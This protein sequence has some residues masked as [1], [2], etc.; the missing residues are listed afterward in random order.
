MQPTTTTPRHARVSLSHLPTPLEP[1]DRLAAHLGRPAGTLWVKR[2]DLTGLAGGGNKVRKLEYVLADALAHGADHVVTLGGPQSNA[3]RMTAAAAARLGLGC[4]LVLDG[5]RPATVSGNLLLDLLCGADIRWHPCDSVEEQEAAIL[6][7]CADLAAAGARPYA[8]TVG[9]SNALGSLGYVDVARE[10]VH[11]LPDVDTVVVA[12][13]SCGTQAGLVAGFGDHA[14]VLGVRVGERR[15][16]A[17]RVARL[18]EETAA[19]AG[20]PTPVGDV[21]LDEDHLGAGYGEHTDATIAAMVV[22]ARLEA[23]VLDPVY[24]GKSF[25]ALLTRLRRGELTDGPVV[26]VHTGGTPGLLSDAHGPRVATHPAVAA[27]GVPT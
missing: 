7:A 8:I 25:A 22:A 26:W 18:A 16:M 10:I 13:G 5:E 27:P 12:T 24:T 11:D 23:L 1:M 3:A 4:T 19:L 15:T 17:A 9:A 6:A 20:L 21:R 2:D 14:R